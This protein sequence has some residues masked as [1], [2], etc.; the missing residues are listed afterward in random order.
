MRVFV[1]LAA[2][3]GNDPLAMAACLRRPP[4]PLTPD[5]VAA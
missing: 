4:R 3:A 2:E 5:E 1:S